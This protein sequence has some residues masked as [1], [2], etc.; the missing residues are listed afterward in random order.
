MGEKYNKY[1]YSSGKVSWVV[2]LDDLDV[3]LK[4]FPLKP[5][6]NT[7]GTYSAVTFGQGVGAISVFS[8]LN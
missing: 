3:T 6:P 4:Q 8:L 2:R 5:L 7:N 1:Y